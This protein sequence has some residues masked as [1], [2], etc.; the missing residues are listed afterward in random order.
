MFSDAGL[1]LR[2]FILLTCLI[3]V[4]MSYARSAHK[5]KKTLTKSRSKRLL[6]HKRA[7]SKTKSRESKGIFEEGIRTHF[8]IAEDLD[9]LN[10]K[11]SP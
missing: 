6:Q 1:K 3:I 5:N 10:I 9:P 7:K 4:S 11:A 2:S 8:E